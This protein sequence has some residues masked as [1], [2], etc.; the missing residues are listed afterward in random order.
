MP[1]AAETIQPRGTILYAGSGEDVFPIG[2]LAIS[3]GEKQLSLAAMI[4]NDKMA[5]DA[6]RESNRLLRAVVVNVSSRELAGASLKQRHDLV[7]TAIEKSIPG[8]IVILGEDSQQLPKDIATD[9]RVMRFSATDSAKRI[10]AL[11]PGR[12]RTLAVNGGHLGTIESASPT[13]AGIQPG[14][15]LVRAANPFQ[16]LA[17]IAN[18][19]DELSR[20]LMEFG[21]QETAAGKDIIGAAARLNIPTIG[22]AN[23]ASSGR[24]ELIIHSVAPSDLI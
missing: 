17:M 16:A 24:G 13:H 19:H 5:A 10:G 7:R 21:M 4:N 18:I 9:P 12:Y 15:E 2:Q 1:N 23:R 6:I 11:L 3:R 22:L 20:I 8:I 14:Q